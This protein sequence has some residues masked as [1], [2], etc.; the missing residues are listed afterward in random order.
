LEGFPVTTHQFDRWQENNGE[1]AGAREPRPADAAVNCLKDILALTGEHL[2][3][4][5]VA[6]RVQA[7]ARAA[8]E[9]LGVPPVPD[10]DDLGGPS[11]LQFDDETA[12]I[13]PEI[14]VEP[15]F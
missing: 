10:S 12:F 5:T 1:P 8:L 3:A 4:A 6:A 7:I 14:D 9:R 2:P 11:G 15:P 13:G